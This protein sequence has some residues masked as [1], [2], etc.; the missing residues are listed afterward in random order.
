MGGGGDYC[1]ACKRVKKRGKRR[2]TRLGVKLKKK[3]KREIIKF[4]SYKLYT[5]T[6]IQ[7]CDR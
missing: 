6:A 5:T 2:F 3:L 7:T 4:L 1:A